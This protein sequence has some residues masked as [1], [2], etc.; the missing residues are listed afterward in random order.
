MQYKEKCE[1]VR[2]L[3]ITGQILVIIYDSCHVTMSNIH[4]NDTFCVKKVMWLI[5]ASFL[6]LILFSNINFQ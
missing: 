3:D 4:V 2:H 5:L 6:K 1:L